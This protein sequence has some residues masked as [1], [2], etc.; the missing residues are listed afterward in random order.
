MLEGRHFYPPSS[1]DVSREPHLAL[2]YRLLQWL[3]R[4]HGLGFSNFAFVLIGNQA[5]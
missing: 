3:D 2:P 5:L 1:R 4:F